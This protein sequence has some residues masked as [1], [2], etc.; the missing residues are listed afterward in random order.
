[1][2]SKT[3]VRQVLVWLLVL[4]LAWP[5]VLP[6]QQGGPEAAATQGYTYT[7]EDLDRLL[8][9]IALYPDT[10]LSQI[11]MAS[12]YPIEVV[13]ADRWLKQR[14]NL[15]GDALDEALKNMPWDV[16]VKS[17]CHFPNVLS[18]MDDKLQETTDL[19]NAFLAQQDQVMDTVQK[20]RARAEAQGNL[21]STEQQRV[22]VQGPDI[23]IE[24]VYPDVIYVPAYD[25]CW[26]YGPWWY[27]EC[28]PL[29]FWWPGLVVGVGFF[30]GP[31][32]ILGPIDLWCGFHWHRHEIFVNVNKTVFVGR[33]N[34]ARVHGG[35]ETWVHDPAHRGGL[36]YPNARTAQRFGRAGGP[37]VEPRRAFRGF[38]PEGRGPG[39]VRPGARPGGIEQPGI[40][41]RGGPPGRG[42]GGRSMEQPGGF[43]QPRGG[44][45]G[46]PSVTRPRGGS[47]FEGF[48]SSSAGSRLNSE[49]GWQSMGRGFQGGFGGGGAPRG[50]GFGGGGHGGGGRGGR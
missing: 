41:P 44:S 19:G 36:A 25:P 18:M 14:P 42:T 11:L 27:P 6:A 46:G 24:P 43:Q 45:L 21:T 33:V 1:M 12:T 8:A 37:G 23:I 26:V 38:A 32:F 31:G 48:G 5:A 30:W 9:P 49:R 2:R 28:S 15:T 39:Q 34:A 17:L 22:V 47:A 3:V 4:L 10:L 35:M 20:L 40:Q 16:S 7:Q 13:E 50:G 29:W